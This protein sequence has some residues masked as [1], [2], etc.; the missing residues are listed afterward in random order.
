MIII[1][2][3]EKQLWNEFSVAS[4]LNKELLS[5]DHAVKQ[6]DLKIFVLKNR[7]LY[8]RPA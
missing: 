7:Y 2:D 1:L 3:H 8:L 4:N 5:I 6:A